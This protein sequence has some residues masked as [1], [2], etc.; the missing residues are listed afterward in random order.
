MHLYFLLCAHISFKIKFKLLSSK[1]IFYG[2]VNRDHLFLA[3]HLFCPVSSNSI[4][5]II[6]FPQKVNYKNLGI[7]TNFLQLKK[8][9]F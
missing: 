6:P 1:K 7:A 4:E 2:R 5:I 3:F 8:K 9:A